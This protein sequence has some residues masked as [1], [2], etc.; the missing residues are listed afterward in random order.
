MPIIDSQLSLVNWNIGGAK[1]L[2]MR[3]KDDPNYDEKKE[4]REAFRKRLNTAL[5]E[6]LRSK[7]QIVALQEVTW[8]GDLGK[9]ECVIQKETIEDAGYIFP[10]LSTKLIDTYHHSHQGKWN[11]LITNGGWSPETFFAQGNAFLVRKDV[12]MQM[13]PVMS[14]PD[15]GVTYDDWFATKKDQVGD[16]ISFSKKEDIFLDTGM[17]FGNRD[18]EPRAATVIHLVV[19]GIN[20]KPQDIFIVNCHLSTLTNEREGIPQMDKA[21]SKKRLV[22]LDTIMDSIIS[23]YHLWRKSEFSLRNEPILL[24]D[25]ETTKRSS[26]IWILVGDFNFTPESDEYRYVKSQNFIDLIENHALGTKAKGVGEYPTLTLDYVFAGPLFESI[27]PNN[28]NRNLNRVLVDDI[29][30]VSDHYPVSIKLQLDTLV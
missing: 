17:Y 1:F 29:N 11:K 30:R 4:S 13:F 2:E 19:S 25:E 7:P 6:L 20:K 24:T 23:P 12:S 15:K 22:Q 5:N 8:Y 10:L 16:K 28:L 3:S 26:P 27:N 14:L 9:E 18:T 21:A